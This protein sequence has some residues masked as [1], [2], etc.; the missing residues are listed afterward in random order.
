MRRRFFICLALVA[1]GL[2]VSAHPNLQDAMWVQ[3]E[4]QRIRVAVN[5][6]LKEIS[7]AQ[8]VTLGENGNLDSPAW[9]AAVERHRDYV[10]KHLTLSVGESILPGQATALERLHQS[11]SVAGV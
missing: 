4:P 2:T 10:L 3:F 6:S 5:V 1:G 8:G 7:V 9:L 11:C